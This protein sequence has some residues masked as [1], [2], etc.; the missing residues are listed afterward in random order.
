MNDSIHGARFG[1]TSGRI[2]LFCRSSAM[3]PECAE[4]SVSNGPTETG[5][6]LVSWIDKYI[7]DPSRVTIIRCAI[8]G[9][10]PLLRRRAASRGH[11]HCMIVVPSG[12]QIGRGNNIRLW[13][14]SA[15]EAGIRVIVADDD[16]AALI[17]DLWEGKLQ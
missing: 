11:G 6:P 14:K 1:S 7:M 3:V 5:K 13:Q 4:S 17:E 15:A 8:T 9:I 2:L 10:S 12:D 16:A